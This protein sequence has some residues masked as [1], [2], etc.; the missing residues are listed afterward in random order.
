MKIDIGVFIFAPMVLTVLLAVLL[1]VV[2]SICYSIEN[3]VR[4][5]WQ[6]RGIQRLKHFENKQRLIAE[7]A[8]FVALAD[9]KSMEG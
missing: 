2:D 7:Y 9:N 5:K 3:A 1:A 6:K 8:E 4:R